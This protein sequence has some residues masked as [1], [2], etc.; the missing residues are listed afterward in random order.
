MAPKDDAIQLNP[1]DYINTLIAQ[2]NAALDEIVKMSAIITAQQRMIADLT[3]KVA[4][5]IP[6]APETPATP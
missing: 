5:E 4:G 2:R 1:Q 6:P 3:P